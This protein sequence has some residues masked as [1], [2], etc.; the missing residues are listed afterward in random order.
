MFS[1][2]ELDLKSLIGACEPAWN[3][4]MNEWMNEWKSLIYFE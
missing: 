3:E 1:L 4:W 2:E